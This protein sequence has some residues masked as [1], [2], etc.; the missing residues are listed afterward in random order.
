MF[1]QEEQQSEVQPPVPKST[2]EI[3]V[4]LLGL[5]NAGIILVAYGFFGLAG[6]WFARKL[7]SQGSTRKG[8]A[9][10]NGCGFR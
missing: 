3:P 2:V 4:W 7:D 10:E 9:G 5:A 1:F 8:L 6:F